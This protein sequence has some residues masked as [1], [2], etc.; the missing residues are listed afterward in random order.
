VS[1]CCK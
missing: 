1:K